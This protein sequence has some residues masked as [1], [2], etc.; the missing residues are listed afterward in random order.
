MSKK[1]LVISSS[2]RVG[3][4]S[5]VLADEFVRGAKTAGHNVEKV[6]LH[7][8]NIHFCRGC[9]SCQKT[10]RCIINDDANSVVE[11]M[12][13]AE[14]LVFATPIY[15]YEMSGQLK[16]LLDRANPLFSADYNFRDVYLLASAADTDEH[17]PDNAENGIKGWVACFEQT[18]F[19]G[20]VFA[21]GVT[22]VGDVKGNS[23]LQQAYEMGKNA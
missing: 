2:F 9:L 23:V 3:G 22:N 13:T 21:G 7:D 5:D 4:N 15:Y 10:L 19:K 6:S 1:I 14:V 16:T 12:K 18:K 11:K 8:K 20:C 17:T